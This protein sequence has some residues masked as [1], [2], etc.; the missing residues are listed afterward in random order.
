MKNE[1]SSN[2]KDLLDFIEENQLD[3]DCKEQLI[4]YVRMKHHII[5]NSPGFR[6]RSLLSESSP[7]LGRKSGFSKESKI[8]EEELI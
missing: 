1:F 2:N 7:L 3:D 4:E 8:T 5:P 6:R